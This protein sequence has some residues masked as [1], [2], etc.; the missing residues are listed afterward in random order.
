[1]P[2]PV[3]KENLESDRFFLAIFS[4]RGPQLRMIGLGQEN[5]GV[6][7]IFESWLK[8]EGGAADNRNS[9]GSIEGRVIGPRGATAARM[10][11][12]SLLNVVSH[13]SRMGTMGVV[14]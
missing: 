5:W 12:A 14:L 11:A 6:Q 7:S 13:D 10:R 4:T 2:D 3:V 8:L 1:M 9:S